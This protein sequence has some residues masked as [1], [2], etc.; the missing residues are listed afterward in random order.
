MIEQKKY[1]RR[2]MIGLSAGSLLAL[3]LWPG[4]WRAEG[5]GN[6]G[7]FSFIVVNDLH[8][9]DEKC[10]PYFEKV[11]AQMKASKVDFCLIVGDYAED[12]KAG[13]IGP[14]NDIF[15]TLG[16]PAY[17]VIGN[18]DYLTQTDRKAYEEIFPD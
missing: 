6:S 1:S 4:A 13:Q 5:E 8:Y 18:H 15:K 11:V 9:H 12:G 17:G 2:D 7:E 3:G 10:G 16:I 14:A